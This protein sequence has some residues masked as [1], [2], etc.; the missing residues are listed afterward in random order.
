MP[1]LLDTA[2]LV[3]V[4]SAAELRAYR[5]GRS[6]VSGPPVRVRPCFGGVSYTAA[7]VVS[8]SATAAGAALQADPRLLGL[9]AAASAACALGAFLCARST[10]A[11]TCL[12][13]YRLAAFAARNGLVYERGASAPGVEGMRYSDSAGEALRRFTGVIDGQHVEAGNYRHVT[14]DISGYV[15]VGET[16]RVVPPFDFAQPAEWWRAW[17]LLTA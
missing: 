17:R 5:R 8:G 14:G 13:E 7:L 1:T 10:R 6:P 16:A 3:A 4:P 9:G 15:V 11:R 2:P 12:L